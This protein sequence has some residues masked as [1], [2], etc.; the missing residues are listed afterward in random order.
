MA[1][2]ARLRYK[3]LVL[4]L[5]PL[6]VD[7]A[8]LIRLI[9]PMAQLE[10]KLMHEAARG[11]RLN[12]VN[13]VLKDIS[14]ALA[15]LM[16]FKIYSDKTYLLKFNEIYSR[17][18]ENGKKVHDLAKIAAKD[19]VAFLQFSATIDDIINHIESLEELMDE[20]KELESIKIYEKV[21]SFLKRLEATGSAV[22]EAEKTMQ[23]Q[24][25]E[26]QVQD[27]EKLKKQVNFLVVLNAAIAAVC[28]G[29][30]VYA[31]GLRFRVLER[32][33][34]N[35]ARGTPLE[36][37]LPGNDELTDLDNVI[38][39]LSSELRLTRAKERSLLDN[40]AEIICSLDEAFRFSEVN[41]AI[42]KRLGY[43]PEELLGTN[44]QTLVH[45]DDKE[46]TYND[47][48]RCKNLAAELSFESRLKRKDGGFIDAEWTVVGSA[49]NMNIFGPADKNSIF[50]LIHDITERKEAERLKQEVIAMVSHDLRAPLT[51]IGLTLEM[52]REGVVGDLD[53][54]GVKFIDRAKVSVTALVHMINDLIDVERFEA[55]SMVLNYDQVVVDEIL[56]SIE[57]VRPE[58]ERK[59]I[60]LE[61][62]PEPGIVEV[63]KERLVRVV[64]NLTNNAIKFTPEGKR[65]TVGTKVLE[66][67]TKPHEIEFF[68]ADEGPG[69]PAEKVELVFEKFQQ[70]GTG[71]E[72]ERKGSGLGLAIC[73]AIAESHGGTIGVESTEGEG[74]RFWFRVP[75]RQPKNQ[76]TSAAQAAQR[77]SQQTKKQS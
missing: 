42:Q 39:K 18:L 51:S 48:T 23:A 11:D 13:A 3:I 22:I 16:M 33:A 27:W 47:L 57:M 45:P 41:S 29:W 8:L 24:E 1:L 53:E 19:E 64:V 54:K 70:V 50:C 43:T 28:F 26:N 62:L 72:G 25:V 12:L 44:I 36:K 60:K 2:R 6:I 9:D 14:S 73:K 75:A 65:I 68:V 20:S 4:L 59:K 10:Q 17:I 32:N 77:S 49:E 37:P 52:V 66:H 67:D 30:F 5:V 58:A 21:V 76:S 63:D 56:A 61:V 35:I 40:T 71:S 55:G 69:I 34:I 74:S 38:H 7:S 15:N 31:F 46:N